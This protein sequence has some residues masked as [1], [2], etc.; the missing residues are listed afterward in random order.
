MNYGELFL[1]N[2][3]K[4]FLSEKK[5]I[6]G[7]LEDNYD[8]PKTFDALFLDYENLLYDKMKLIENSIQISLIQDYENL[9][10][11]R[12][13]TY[14]KDAIIEVVNN[15]ILKKFSKYNDKK[16]LDF[17]KFCEYSSTFFLL[18]DFRGL[19]KRK[20]Y[21]IKNA[22]KIQSTKG[23]LKL[24]KNKY[25]EYI[26]NPDIFPT[27]AEKKI[28]HDYLTSDPYDNPF[29]VDEKFII[30]NYFIELISKNRFVLSRYEE[31]IILKLIANIYVN[32]PFTKK[33]DTFYE[34]YVKGINYSKKS[35]AFKKKQLE[36][37]IQKSKK[38]DIPKF[39]QYLESE[40]NKM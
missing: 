28:K 1:K 12:N 26:L 16:N 4:K 25:G 21:D 37:I 27:V 2:Y 23:L 18:N 5:L 33:K 11:T 36:D 13:Y 17:Q 32:K 34:K 39:I 40:L 20:R 31:I 38:F 22:F 14:R 9:F 29:S 19:I 10:L 7:Y 24:K 30:S 8:S 3:N 15:E 35:F 6:I